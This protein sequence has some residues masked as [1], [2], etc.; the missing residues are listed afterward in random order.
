MVA[1][2]RF[3]RLAI[4]LL[5]HARRGI[6]GILIS[7][8]MIRFW[9]AIILMAVPVFMPMSIAVTMSMIVPMCAG[10]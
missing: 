6:A 9:V 2:R 4:A 7:L 3:R 10:W 8:V 5:P 1:L